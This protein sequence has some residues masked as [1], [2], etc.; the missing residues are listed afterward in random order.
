MV[1]LFFFYNKIRQIWWQNHAPHPLI[2]LKSFIFRLTI[3]P[4]ESYGFSKLL[5][6]M[7]LRWAKNWEIFRTPSELG[8]LTLK[9]TVF[10]D[11]YFLLIASEASGFASFKL[12]SSKTLNSSSTLTSFICKIIIM[13]II[14]RIITL[15][16]SFQQN[17]TYTQKHEKNFIR[18]VTTDQFRYNHKDFKGRIILDSHYWHW[19]NNINHKNTNK[20]QFPSFTL[21]Q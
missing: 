1:N 8:S 19:N 15:L 2:T 7:Y 18:R 12:T 21:F 13:I 9:P 14:T 16:I 4:R 20:T 6:Y 10:E 5:L 17:K 11:A 3:L